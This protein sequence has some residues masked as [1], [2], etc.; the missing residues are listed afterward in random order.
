MAVRAPE[1]FLSDKIFKRLRAQTELYATQLIERYRWRGTYNGVLPEAQDAASIADHALLQVFQHPNQRNGRTLRQQLRHIRQQLQYHVRKEINRLHHR[2][3]N[4]CLGNVPDL[5][6]IWC[7]DG[8]P[9]SPIDLIRD[10]GPSPT[11]NIIWDEEANRLHALESRFLSYLGNRHRLKTL[12]RHLCA[13]DSDPKSLARK[14]KV[15]IP[16]VTRLKRRLRD[17]IRAFQRRKTCEKIKN[18]P[19]KSQEYFVDN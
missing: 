9:D 4:R 8:K 19:Q 6:P 5:K 15:K 11:D 2:K 17:Q 3:E 14:L 16:A 12:F 18:H 1:H 13:G 10:P 7:A